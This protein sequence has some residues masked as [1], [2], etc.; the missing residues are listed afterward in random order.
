MNTYAELIKIM[1][2]FHDRENRNR[3]DHLIWFYRKVCHSRQESQIGLQTRL[4]SGG[5]KKGGGKGK[6]RRKRKERREKEKE[7]KER[8]YFR[9]LIFL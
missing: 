9:N 8:N 4:I 3:G 7:R 1:Q 5:K 6:E 2:V